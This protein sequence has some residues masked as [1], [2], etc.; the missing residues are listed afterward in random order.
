M[1]ITVAIIYLTLLSNLFPKQEKASEFWI[2]CDSLTDVIFVLD[3]VVQL[4]T[5]YLEQGLMV[6]MAVITMIDHP[7]NYLLTYPTFN[8]YSRGITDKHLFILF[9]RFTTAKNWHPII[10]TQKSFYLI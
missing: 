3:V 7:L 8:P 9:C 1:A 5:G 6:R 10:Y 4:R 2:V